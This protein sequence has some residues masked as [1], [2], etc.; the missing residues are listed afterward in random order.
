MI[1]A[2]GIICGLAI[3]DKL[4]DD[5]GITGR[6]VLYESKFFRPYKDK[7]TTL[8]NKY[9]QKAG[10]YVIK[11][12]QDGKI[13]YVGHGVN[14]LKKTLYRHF[15]DWNDTQQ[16]RKVYNKSGY[17]VKIYRTT[18]RDAPKLEKYLIDKYKPIHNKLK[19]PSLFEQGETENPYKD[20]FSSYVKE[21]EELPF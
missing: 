13:K 3:I 9:Y 7:K 14:N 11:S 20:F 5:A 16:D 2:I 15:Q 19:Y 21:K 18:K 6:K 1:Q 8:P 12:K 17:L 10:V 4:T